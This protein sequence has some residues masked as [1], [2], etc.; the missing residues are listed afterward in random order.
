MNGLSDPTLG[1]V[2]EA[3]QQLT[4][5]DL[6][7]LLLKAG[8]FY[9]DTQDADK[10]ELIRWRILRA[11]DE[12][13]DGDD[14]AARGLLRFATELIQRTVRN[15][16]S[17]PSWFGELRGALLADGYELMWDGTPTSTIGSGWNTFSTPRPV[18]RRRS[19]VPYA[20]HHRHGA[21]PA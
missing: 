8:I 16:E 15:P 10:P 6:K 18:R 2:I 7:T 14:A 1:V 4:R 3:G 13:R 19:P 21:L 12:A 5:T 11:R 20:G 17:P 9:R